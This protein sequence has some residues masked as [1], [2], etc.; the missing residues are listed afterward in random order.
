MISRELPP[1][2]LA[3]CLVRARFG[4]WS[5]DR[6]VFF[7]SYRYPG[8]GL[9]NRWGLMTKE[10]NDL[11]TVHVTFEGERIVSFRFSHAW[12]KARFRNGRSHFMGKEFQLPVAGVV[13]SAE[14][15]VKIFKTVRA[16]DGLKL[17]IPFWHRYF[18][19]LAP[20]LEAILEGTFCVAKSGLP[21]LPIFQRNHPSWEDDEY[22]RGVLIPVL[23]AWL[24]AGSLEYVERFHRLPHCIL[25]VGAVEKATA[26][27][28]RLVTDARPIN[29]FAES[30]R[31]KYTT[32]GDVCLT[33]TRA[34]LMWIRDLK[35]AYHLVRLGG[36]RGR[37]E[38]LLRWI[39]NAASTGY[40]P[41]PT[42]RS[43]CSPADCLG[44]C[45]KAMFG[46]CVEGHVMRFAVAQFGHKVSNGPLWIITHTVCAYASRVHGIDMAEFVDDLLK[47]L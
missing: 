27:F 4:F 26:P 20:E 14:R 30:W 43:G 8:Q 32:V 39:T 12:P 38:R 18:G 28:R 9:A 10:A 34:A 16:S 15:P 17:A 44:C 1:L 19:S 2:A 40:M 46:I 23:S 22:A 42:F 7:P 13:G 35:N 36:C 33:L 5:D 37:T 3:R 25:A 21:L 31:V 11:G 41:T 45:D 29:V 6:R 24:M 47:I